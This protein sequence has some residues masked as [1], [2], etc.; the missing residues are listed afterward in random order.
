V[1]KINCHWLSAIV[2]SVVPFAGCAAS[3]Q[4]VR[5]YWPSA[6]PRGI[7][8]VVNGSG[9]FHYT[10]EAFQKAIQESGLALAVEPFEWS[11]GVGRFVADQ[12]SWGHAK[13]EGGRLAA[14]IAAYRQ[15]HCGGQIFLVG[16]SA[17]S[18]VALAAAE[19]SSPDTIDRIILLAPSVSADYDLRPALRASRLGVD[20]FYSSRDIGYL[21]LG[22]ALI[23][24]VD[25][26]GRAAAGR[27]GFRPHV[28]TM[29]DSMIYNKLRQHPW[30]PCVEWTG[31]IGG[32]YGSYQPAY[33]RAYVLPLFN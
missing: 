22:V 3:R 13:A 9:G 19:G 33:L 7:V 1:A 23:G 5:S 16:Y 6:N 28:E 31:N 27:V 32:H 10:S 24:T 11:H 17:G 12:T 21:G 25:H 15:S 8:Y 2:L 29:D 30:N 4:E 14:C 26:W 20:V 18:A